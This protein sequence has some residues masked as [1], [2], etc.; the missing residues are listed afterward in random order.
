MNAVHIGHAGGVE[1][2]WSDDAG[3]DIVIT[4]DLPSPV[5][6]AEMIV[7]LMRVYKELRSHGRK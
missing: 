6:L 2:F 7:E 3:F 1:L 4:G 5:Q